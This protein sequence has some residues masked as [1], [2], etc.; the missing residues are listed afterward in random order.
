MIGEAFDE[1]L[2]SLKNFS[3]GFGSDK[4]SEKKTRVYFKDEPAKWMTLRHRGSKSELV[5]YGKFRKKVV[6]SIVEE[7]IRLKC[8][9]CTYESVGSESPSSDYDITVS[10]GKASRV[11]KYFNNT[12]T[13]LFGMDSGTMFDTNV[14]GV[15]FMKKPTDEYK[16]YEINGVV[17]SVVNIGNNE[18]ELQRKDMIKQH[19]WALVKF[20]MYD[21][22]P[23]LFEFHDLS[24]EWKESLGRAQR[25]LQKKP[26]ETKYAKRVKEAERM[27]KIMKKNFKHA[28]YR[29]R[30]KDR[31]SAANYNASETY[32][33]Q[34]AF[35]DVVINQQMGGNVKMTK[36]E[37]VDSA[38]E[39]LGYMKHVIHSMRDSDIVDMTVACSKYWSRYLSAS[40]RVLNNSISDVYS[41]L[42]MRI[43]KHLRGKE[44]LSTLENTFITMILY[45]L[46]INNLS[47]YIDNEMSKLLRVG[48]VSLKKKFRK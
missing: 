43:K 31:V 30:Y 48:V 11:I 40:S 16:S 13:Q 6:N 1:H 9:T 18:K 5:A 44:K 45:K 27:E 20:M 24:T 37:Y 4:Y 35:I 21:K 22:H 17:M 47:V 32:L 42:F 41:K 36:S 38:I 25:H 28:A 39:N 10:T 19:A 15:S 12:F 7:A 23:G 46:D 2:G 3:L 8:P 26:D 33:T 34:G 29:V 14:Y